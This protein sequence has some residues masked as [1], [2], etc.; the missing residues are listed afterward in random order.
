MKINFTPLLNAHESQVLHCSLWADVV[1]CRAC[2][3]IFVQLL[4]QFVI[5]GASEKWG[6]DG[7]GALLDGKCVCLCYL[8]LHHK[9]WHSYPGTMLANWAFYFVTSAFST[10]SLHHYCCCCC[11]CS[12]CCCCKPTTHC[13]TSCDPVDLL[14]P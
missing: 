8:P 4:A 5:F 14:P 1:P 2:L 7:G 11:C 13:N 3:K 9:V 10:N 6:D 12:C